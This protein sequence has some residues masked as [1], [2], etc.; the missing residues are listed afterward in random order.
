MSKIEDNIMTKNDWANEEIEW[1]REPS[2][3]FRFEKIFDLTSKKQKQRSHSD[4][5]IP[6]Q[7]QQSHCI[8][9]K[10]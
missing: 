2:F 8:F 9:S 5:Q 3:E 1:Q 4:K 10:R 7:F 6:I